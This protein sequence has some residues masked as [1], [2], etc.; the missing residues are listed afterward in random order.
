MFT[1]DNKDLEYLLGDHGYQ[2][3]NMYIMRR[4]GHQEMSCKANYDAI[5]AFDKV[6]TSYKVWVKW[7]I[8]GLKE[9]EEGLG[10]GSIQLG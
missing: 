3:Q 5:D 2:L 1:H 9:S 8:E 10:E 6:Y 4:L 7:G